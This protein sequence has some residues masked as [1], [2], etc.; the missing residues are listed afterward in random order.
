[1][2][3]ME[4]HPVPADLPDVEDV[5]I[6]VLPRARIIVAQVHRTRLILAILPAK[7]H[8]K[9]L[10]KPHVCNHVNTDLNRKLYQLMN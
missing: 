1:M 3:L 7:E 5:P 8:V 10:V 2:S 4:D 9:V 6:H